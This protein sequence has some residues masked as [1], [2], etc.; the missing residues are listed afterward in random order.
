MHSK[1]IPMHLKTLTAEDLGLPDT[2][3]IMSVCLLED[4]LIRVHFHDKKGV[5][6]DE[7]LALDFS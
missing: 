7:Q 6:G 5:D 3:R 2:V 4:Q 1:L